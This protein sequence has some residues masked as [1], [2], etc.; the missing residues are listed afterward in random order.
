[1]T[2][3]QTPERQWLL[4]LAREAGDRW[5]DPQTGLCLI[6]R[7]TLWYAAGLLCDE[8]EDRRAF[9]RT[10]ISRIRAG[11]GTHTPATMLA[12]LLGL[13]DRLDEQCRTHL[14]R[15]IADELPRAS[16]VQWR[17]GN[18]NHPLGAYAALILGGE[19][20]GLSW[21]SA[22]GYRRLLEFQQTTGDRRTRCR[23]QAEMSEY[24]SPTYTA[25]NLVFLGLIAGYVRDGASRALG[26]WLEQRLWLDVALHFHQTS[27]QI[28]GPH[29]RSYQE[30]STGGF[31][32]LHGVL[33]AGTGRQMYADPSLSVQFDH[34]ST[35]LQSGLTAI[36][37]LHPTDAAVGVM[38]EKPL[39][40]FMRKTTY[41]EQYHE[42]A[43]GKG[44]NFDDEVYQG[45]W[46][47]LTTYMNEEWAL[48]TASLPYVNAGH[49]DC[50]MVRLRRSE[51]IERPQDFRSFYTRGVFNDSVVGQQNRCHV[52]GGAIDASY[53]YEESRCAVYQHRD[54][55]I[56]FASPKR[57]GH[58]DVRTFRLDVIAGWAAPFDELY[59]DDKLV[60]RFPFD[61]E[62]P[63][64][65]CFRDFRT[66]GLLIPL[67]LSPMALR[68]PF[69]LWTA[70]GHIMLSLFNY[71][72]PALNLSRDE[73]TEWR[74]GFILHLSTAR[75]W[76]SFEDFRRWTK[77]MRVAETVLAGRTR[78]VVYEAPDGIMKAE[79]DPWR[80]CFVAR[81]WNGVE[82][83]VT[84]LEI[85]AGP[86]R[87]PLLD[88][89]TIFGSEARKS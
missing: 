20:C 71:D 77:T 7:D 42:N 29:S 5:F 12:I 59:L 53:L 75:E 14:R 52:T 27:M 48:G 4:R 18:V 54:R 60:D 80:E 58:R 22:L 62:V 45:G 31:S 39:P 64:R 35:L 61:A 25:L 32:A 70:N 23:R 84:H 21:A 44:F 26:L 73:L 66:Y 43:T 55:A 76:K 13:D 88:P 50:V 40:L 65:L 16:T 46:R 3:L 63:S 56:V 89:L 86:D 17:D 19:V 33:I 83:E 72:G 15:E 74:N 1:M 49:S 51:R 24:N 41:S 78:Q 67:T 57:A 10:L 69:R 34:P 82:E 2:N 28:A 37:P 30:D 87:L 6:G 85:E 47:D 68:T 11:D 81:T 38:W 79:Y 36:T 9:A 8:G